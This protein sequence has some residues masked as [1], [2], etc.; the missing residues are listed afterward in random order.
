MEILFECSKNTLMKSS[1]LDSCLFENSESS[2]KLFETIIIEKK[3]IINKKFFAQQNN[4]KELFLKINS[5]PI[6][7][8]NNEIMYF[9]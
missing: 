6:Y 5:A 8:S 7:D 2:T 9:F 3:N 1:F 4:G